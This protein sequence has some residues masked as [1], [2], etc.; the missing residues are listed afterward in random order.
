MLR[1]LRLRNFAVVESVTVACEPGL[2][3]L[4]GE[5]GAGKSIVV[6][7]IVL[8]RGGRAQAD[9]IRTDADTATVEALFEVPKGGAVEALLA[10]AGLGAEEG[11]VVVR[12]ELARSG[13]HRA[14]V[15]DSPVTVGLLERLGEVLVDVH[16]QHEHQRLLQTGAQLE[17]LDR[18]AEADGLREA[19]GELYLRHRAAAEALAGLREA[20]RDRAQREDLLRFQV[21]ELTAAGLRAGE[22]DELQ[23]ERRRLQ[24]ADRSAASLGEVMRLLHDDPDAAVSR[25]ARA[26]RLLQDL[27]RVDPAFGG[28]AEAVD[29]TQ[30]QT[31]EAVLALRSL[32]AGIE[33]DPERLEAI[34][35]RLALLARLKRKYG[36]TVEAM[37]AFRATAAG[38]LE[39]LERHEEVV[40]AQTR[41]VDE[42]AAELLAAA[43]TLSARRRT[44][45]GRLAP[46]VQRE[47]RALGMERSRFEVALDGAGTAGLGPRG[48]DRVE[49]RFSANPGEELRPLARIA[50]GGELSRSM[51]ALCAVLAAADPVPTLVFDEVDAGIGG[52]VAHVVA[53]KLGQA[54]AGRQVLCVTHLPAIAARAEHHLRVSKAVR[55]GRTRATVEVLTGE[56][57]VEELARML[58]GAPVTEAARRHAREL[59]R[60]A[61]GTE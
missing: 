28:P 17:V 8:V 54:A 41:R 14:F 2:N 25:L 5:T 55:S 21:S 32:R 3:V 44:A 7:A 20:E 45:A 12:R 57:R 23:L 39:R 38:E 58:G 48:L 47:L 31:A 40:G 4:S 52:A 56:I 22:E 1:E 9:I 59:L 19:V 42:L 49:F 46:A 60:R 36:D 34:E 13:R 15:N 53:Q 11:Q 16:G 30:I 50:S 6:D 26:A 35:E 33:P 61:R 10:G 18:F 43:T 51:L 27:G 24:H 37:L 29:A